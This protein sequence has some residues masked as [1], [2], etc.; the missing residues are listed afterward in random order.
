[1]VVELHCP[2]QINSSLRHYGRSGRVTWPRGCERDKREMQGKEEVNGQIRW[3][4]S[5]VFVM[6]HTKTM[7][8]VSIC[9]VVP[10]T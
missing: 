2:V 5:G 1:M 7:W 9:E 6:R 4:E 8:K 10:L 3:E